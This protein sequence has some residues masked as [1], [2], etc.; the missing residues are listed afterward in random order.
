MA[1][2][3]VANNFEIIIETGVANLSEHIIVNIFWKLGL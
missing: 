1:T 2:E 3:V